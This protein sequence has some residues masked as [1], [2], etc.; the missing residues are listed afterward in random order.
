MRASIV[1]IGNSRGV[2]IP[3]PLLDQTGLNGEV[4][5]RAEKDTLVIGPARRPREGWAAAFREMAQRG[6]DQL[7]DAAPSWTQWDQDEWEW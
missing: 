2:R 6:E 1:R 3:K 7:L 4:D 5:I